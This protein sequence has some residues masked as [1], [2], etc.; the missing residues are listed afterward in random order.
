MYNALNIC[1]LYSQTAG[2]INLTSFVIRFSHLNKR[3]F[4][5]NFRCFLRQLCFR[6]FKIETSVHF[7]L[8]CNHFSSHWKT[9]L[10]ALTDI[11]NQ[12]IFTFLETASDLVWGL[13]KS[14]FVVVKKISLNECL[15][16]C[17]IVILQNVLE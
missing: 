13:I 16:K 6:S 9:L 2:S 10:K 8:H 17:D 11:L 7:I 1:K 4:K 12:I 14:T 15:V 5:Q 3:I